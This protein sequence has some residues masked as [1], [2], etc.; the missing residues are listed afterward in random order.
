MDLKPE[1]LL[2]IYA[3]VQLNK[4][5]HIS[6]HFQNIWNGAGGEENYTIF[7]IRTHFNF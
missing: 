1:Q 2:E 4:W 6:P 5:T 3:R 7:G